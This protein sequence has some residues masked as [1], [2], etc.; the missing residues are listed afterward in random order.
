[1]DERAWSRVIEILET[2]PHFFVPVRDLWRALRDEGT[3]PADLDLYT[4]Y[5]QL[6]TDERFE[7]IEGIDSDSELGE[8]LSLFAEAMGGLGGPQVKLAAR[9]M[10]PE[11]VF[12]GLRQSLHQLSEALRGAW[13]NRPETDTET[14]NQLLQAIAAADKLEQEVLDMIEGRQARDDAAS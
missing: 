13:E 5:S 4:F 7:L 14:D 1:M 12:A 9:Q 11:D 6:A 3:L 2:T 8:S 10:T